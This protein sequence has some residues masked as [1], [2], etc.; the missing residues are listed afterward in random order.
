MVCYSWCWINLVEIS[1]SFTYNSLFP[2][3]F[4][5]NNCK[6]LLLILFFCFFFFTWTPVHGCG[7]LREESMGKKFRAAF[8]LRAMVLGSHFLVLVLWRQLLP[9][10]F[11]LN[12]MKQ[13]CAWCCMLLIISV[14]SLAQCLTYISWRFLCSTKRR[15]DNRKSCFPLMF[16]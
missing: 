13:F 5:S 4:F 16:L 15:Q 2:L 8:S 6:T 7:A 9:Y 12:Q 3:T 11:I 14:S 10:E 1:L